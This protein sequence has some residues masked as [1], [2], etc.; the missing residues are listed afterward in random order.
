MR[1]G[2]V[3]SAPEDQKDW[4][5]NTMDYLIKAL[6]Q[7]PELA[8]FLAL[9]IG[10]AIGRVKVGGF[11]YPIDSIYKLTR[12]EARNFARDARAS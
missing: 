4:F 6:Q 8:I 10:F 5:D 2:V 1:C 7:N 3:G 9:A 12:E 11:S